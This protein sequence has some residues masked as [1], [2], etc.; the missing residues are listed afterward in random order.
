MACPAVRCSNQAYRET[1][2]GPSAAARWFVRYRFC[3]ATSGDGTAGGRFPT[4]S[5][6]Y[7][8]TSSTQA[9]MD[10]GIVNASELAVLR[11]TTSSKRVG[12]SI[13]RSVGLAP[14][15]I[16]PTLA[17]TWCHVRVRLAP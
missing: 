17:P 11:L 9:R 8:I 13:G 16:L 12:C 7:S 1:Y 4:L 14:L 2:G 15:S 6:P 10:G 5:N 3:A